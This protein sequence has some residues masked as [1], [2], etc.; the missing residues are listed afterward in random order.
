VD[1]RDTLRHR[2]RNAVNGTELPDTVGSQKSGEALHSALSLL[3]SVVRLRIS[4]RRSS[5]LLFVRDVEL[6]LL[7]TSVTIGGVGGVE[8]IRVANP[9]DVLVFLD[10]VEEGEVELRE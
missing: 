7:D 9:L 2:T 4:G 5:L 3:L 1:D 6:G 8:L 10:D